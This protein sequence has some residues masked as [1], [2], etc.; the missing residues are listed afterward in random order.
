ME[1][2]CK[3]S[4]LVCTY[5]RVQLLMRCLN[6]LAKQS[7]PSD[8]Y[9]IIVVDNN[10]SDSTE[11]DVAQFIATHPTLSV[12]YAKESNQGLSHARNHGLQLANGQY[13]AYL[14][15]DA[16]AV[17]T[18][19]EKIVNDFNTPTPTP[20]AVGGPA[21]PFFDS[22]PPPWF[23]LELERRYW[24]DTAGFLP[25]HRARYGFGGLNMAFP[26]SILER[27]G[28][29]STE[30]GVIGNRTRMGEETDL[31]FKIWRDNPERRDTLFWYD[32]DASVAHFTP[33]RNTRPTYRFERALR[34]GESNAFIEE[35][36]PAS[37]RFWL[38]LVYLLKSL[39]FYPMHLL[40]DPG[41]LK[42]R[43]L[44]RTVNLYYAIGYLRGGIF[45]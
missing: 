25:A 15:D 11:E 3:L 23:P 18:W 12:R 22:P 9:E 33:K 44:L 38:M 29:F 28:G 31:F 4:I 35:L 43:W 21:E 13:I 16:I 7:I 20:L 34:S 36:S 1:N 32:P 41:S 37:G 42:R 26:R 8:Q 30:L 17:A 39:L 27:Y 19:A 45:N 14:D 6:A 24:G 5:N 40:T 10:S 2:P